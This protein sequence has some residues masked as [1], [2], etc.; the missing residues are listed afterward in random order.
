[1]IE[2]QRYPLRPVVSVPLR[3]IPTKNCYSIRDTH[4]GDS[5][6][7]RTWKLLGLKTVLAAAFAV[8]PAAAQNAATKD[9]AADSMKIEEI[10]KLLHDAN[11]QKELADLRSAIGQLAQRLNKV[12]AVV[13]A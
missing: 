5:S 10:R 11:I 8:V 9:A 3:P 12:E 6:M 7:H 13:Q 1:S 4:Q 2:P